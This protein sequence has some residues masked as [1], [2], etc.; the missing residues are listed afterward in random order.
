MQLVTTLRPYNYQIDLP[1]KQASSKARDQPVLNQQELPKDYATFSIQECEQ[2]ADNKVFSSSTSS[3]NHS[4]FNS[5]GDEPP[6]EITTI[7][8]RPRQHV[9]KHLGSLT[10][11]QGTG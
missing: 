5:L 3:R 1:F 8:H 4:H 10:L 11:S 9:Q 2:A 6:K 7:E